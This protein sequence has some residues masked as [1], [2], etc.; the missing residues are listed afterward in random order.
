MGFM[1]FGKKAGNTNSDDSFDVPP[2]PPL[3]GRGNKPIPDKPLQSEPP[4]Q[5]QMPPP[6][7]P[8][9]PP[10]SKGNS[11]YMPP[12]ENQSPDLGM[13]LSNNSFDNNQLPP[14]QHDDTGIDIPPIA[15]LETDS[16]PARKSFGELFKS[17]KTE[18][19]PV[20]EPESEPEPEPEP[21]PQDEPAP[22]P[23][24]EPEEPLTRGTDGKRTFIE[25]NRYRQ[26]LKDLKNIRKSLK[27]SDGEISKIIGDINDEERIFSVL[28]A[29]LTDVEQKLSRLENDFF[30]K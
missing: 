2:P 16:K 8:P 9:A 11:Q 15:N 6:I 13:P 21:E 27:D 14:E 20:P 28:H 5:Q 30:H 10:R 22:E 19:E 26:I 4:M 17:P 23:E 29:T 1:K 3:G 7:V 12:A 24:P 25:V 18:P